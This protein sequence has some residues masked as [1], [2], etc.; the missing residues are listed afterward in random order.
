ML[1]K[2]TP[3]YD[4]VPCLFNVCLHLGDEITQKGR[5]ITAG[6]K[7]IWHERC[8]LWLIKLEPD[9]NDNYEIHDESYLGWGE[10]PCFQ[11]RVGNTLFAKDDD[12]LELASFTLPPLQ[13]LSCLLVQAVAGWA[14][15][16]QVVEQ[17]WMN[18]HAS[19]C[20]WQVKQQQGSWTFFLFV[21][22]S[23]IPGAGKVLET[24]ETWNRVHCAVVLPLLPASAHAVSYT[25]KPLV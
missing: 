16:P 12:E 22:V 24:A 5:A 14:K 4:S 9:N 11:V 6:C 3:A 17:A 13:R 1:S 21:V 23:G 25:T 8:R 10:V 20:W 7:I 19:G 15:S 2:K 18:L